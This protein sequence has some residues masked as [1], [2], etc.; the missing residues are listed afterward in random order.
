[1]SGPPMSGPPF[2][3][4]DGTALQPGYPPYGEAPPAPK[5]KRGLLIAS[6]VLAVALLLCGGG[7]TAA[8]LVLRNAE[9]GEGAPTPT[10]AVTGFLTAVYTE[11]DAA[12]AATLVCPAAR[13]AKAIAK[14]VKQVQDLSQTYK[15]PRFSWLIPVVGD[16]NQERAIVSVKVTM[17][18]ADEKVS[19]QELKFTVVQESGWWVCEV[20]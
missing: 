11:Q 17:A 18:T 20:A 2:V 13:D 10:E 14:R 1:M 3:G 12:R 9:S 4:P 19:H 16:Q 6:I 15:S 8:F 5:K 7:G